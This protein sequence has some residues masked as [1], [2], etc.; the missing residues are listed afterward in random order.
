MPGSKCRQELR[1]RAVRMVAVAR[2]DYPSE[3]A[4]LVAVADKLGIATPETLR[5]WVRHAQVV[6][7][8]GPGMAS[9]EHEEIKR[10]PYANP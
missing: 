4:R 5:H 1:E 8:A 3:W 2:P 6:S 9:Q 7:R 10:S